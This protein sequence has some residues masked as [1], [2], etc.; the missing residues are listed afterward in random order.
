MGAAD[1]GLIVAFGAGMLSFL[2]PCVLPLVPG[3]LSLMSGVSTAAVVE[4]REQRGREGTWR[5]L[6]STLL[7][8]AGFTVVFVALGAAATS[9]GRTLLQNQR[10]L[11]LVAGSLILVMGLVLASGVLPRFLAAEKRMQVSPSKLGGFA[12]PVMGA[13]FAFGWTPCIGPV[14]AATLSLAAAG[15]TLGKGML[16]LLAYSFGLAVPFIA[17]GLGFARLT[18]VFGWFRRHARVVNAVSG[19][20]LAAFGVVLLLDRVGWLSAQLVDFM[21]RIGLDRLTAI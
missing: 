14:L 9:L 21:T 11:N 7:F 1:P 16:L 3:Y 17:A 15:A 12:A 4:G 20:T 18:G 19:L 10:T 13:A 2:S 5:I 8:S 6:R